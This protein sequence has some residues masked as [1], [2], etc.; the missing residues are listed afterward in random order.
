MVVKKWYIF[1]EQGN[2]SEKFLLESL[3]KKSERKKIYLFNGMGPPPERKLKN[4][5]VISI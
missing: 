4:A 2:T 5:L 1:Y 3:E